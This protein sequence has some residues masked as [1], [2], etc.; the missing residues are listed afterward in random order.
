MAKI[1]EVKLPDEYKDKN[2]Y[3]IYTHLE[4]V[5]SLAHNLKQQIQDKDAEIKLRDAQLQKQRADILKL[6]SLVGHKNI[7]IHDLK[8]QS[9]VE[10]AEFTIV[11]KT[12]IPNIPNFLP[13]SVKFHEVTAEFKK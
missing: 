7:E 9:E 12:N 3:E 8:L 13:A 5:A 10:D 4:Q 1:I 11:N 2:K 6:K